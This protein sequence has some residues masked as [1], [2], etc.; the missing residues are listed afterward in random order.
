MDGTLQMTSVSEPAAASKDS[1]PAMFTRIE[2]EFPESLGS[3]TWYLV[4]A[5]ALMSFFH[6]S[7][8]ADLYKHLTSQSQYRTSEQRI[9]LSKR[10]R[11]LFLKTWT[12]VGI[13]PVVS[14]AVALAAVEDER[15]VDDRSEQ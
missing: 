4:V 1:L 14:A 9:L 12:L 13:P 7:C 15:D 11:D 2:A 8:I 3:A 6:P 10:L 5:S